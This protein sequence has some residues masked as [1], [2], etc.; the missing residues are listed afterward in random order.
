MCRG[1]S[2]VD[3][4]GLPLLTFVVL[5][6]G[7]FI[8]EAIAVRGRS[9]RQAAGL[10]IAALCIPL[11]AFSYGSWRVAAIDAAPST[12][13]RLGFV[14]PAVPLDDFLRHQTISHTDRDAEFAQLLAATADLAARHPDLDLLVWPE[15]PLSLTQ[16]NP[17]DAARIAGVLSVAHARGVP[18]LF[19]GIGHAGET[20]NAPTTSRL[21][22]ATASGAFGPSYDKMILVPFAEFL[23]STVSCRGYATSLRSRAT[24]RAAPMRRRSR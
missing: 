1:S 20:P 16:G 21:F 17:D 19:A 3:L 5:L 2:I 11:L 6:T 15:V 4:G 8:A 13:L 22:T 18:I 12:A 7:A 10:V 23:R 9:R 24:T 14:Q